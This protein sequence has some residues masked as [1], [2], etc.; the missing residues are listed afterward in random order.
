M[1][2]GLQPNRVLMFSVARSGIA[3]TTEDAERQRERDRRAAFYPMAIERLRQRPDVEAASLTIGLAFWSGFG[4]DIH[5]PGLDKVPQLKGGGPFLS[6]VTADYFKTVG[7]RI[8]RGRSTTPA[9][10][11]GSAPVAIVNETM[12][13]ALWPGKDAIGQCFTIEQSPDCA[14]EIVGIAANTRHFKLQEDES[15]S[16]YIPFGQEQHIGGT[17]LIVRPRG[18]ANGVLAD[19]RQELLSLDPSITFVDAGILQDRVEPQ[20]RPWE[21]GATMFSLMGVLALVVAAMGALAACCDVVLGQHAPHARDRRTAWRSA[22]APPMSRRSPCGS[23][24]ALVLGGLIV[25]FRVSRS[26][27]RRSSHRCC[28]RR[29]RAT[30]PSHVP[31]WPSPS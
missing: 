19:V 13:A 10:R 21:L 12:A 18:D 17:E 4:E 15:L 8:I 6:A 24:L 27:P 7:T 23:G 1:D 29:R 9:D 16:F 2:L 30:R 14:A 3:A 22:R 31:R 5:V 20:V 25:G 11:A 26:S 28:L